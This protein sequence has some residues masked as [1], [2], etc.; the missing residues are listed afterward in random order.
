MLHLSAC[1]SWPSIN[2]DTALNSFLRQQTN[3]LT[4][5][6]KQATYIDSPKSDM[7]RRGRPPSPE[8]IMW[9]GGLFDPMHK[10]SE[11]GAARGLRTHS[12]FRWGL[13]CLT[14]ERS[15]YGLVLFVKSQS[16]MTKCDENT[17][18]GCA[19]NKGKSF[20]YLVTQRWPCQENRGS[21]FSPS[22]TTPGGSWGST[23]RMHPLLHEPGAGW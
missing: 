19:S 4:N 7:D 17:R 2:Q 18:I 1:L 20:D 14:H 23:L 16:E 9:C 8:S 22:A 3:P 10:N 5:N 15:C 11:W 6:Q 13:S 21:S 12:D